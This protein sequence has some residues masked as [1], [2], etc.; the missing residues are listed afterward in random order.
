M[1]EGSTSNVFWIDAGVVCTSPLLIGLLPGVTRAAVFE[2]CDALGVARAERTVEPEQLF[3]SEGV[4]LSLSSRG[5]VEAES[6]EGRP[7]RRSA[8]TARLQKEFEA[9]LEKECA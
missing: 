6:L 5:I 1:A 2:L 3:A 8:V 4:F 9:L 7:L